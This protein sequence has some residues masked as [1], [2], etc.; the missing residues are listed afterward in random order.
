MGVVFKKVMSVPLDFPISWSISSDRLWG[1]EATSRVTQTGS[2]WGRLWDR[3][4]GG[5]AMG[6]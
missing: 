1:T 5:L 6:D 3:M 4:G 2:D